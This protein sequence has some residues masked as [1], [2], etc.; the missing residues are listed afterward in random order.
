MAELAA[1][2]VNKESGRRHLCLSTVFQE[3]LL[4]IRKHTICPSGSM[5][6]ILSPLEDQCKH[7]HVNIHT[8]QIYTYLYMYIYIQMCAYIFTYIYICAYH[9]LTQ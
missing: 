4:G 6:T 1:I 3:V 7:V 5:R 2:D 8:T 9:T